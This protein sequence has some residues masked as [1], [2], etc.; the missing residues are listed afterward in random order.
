ML[1]RSR[2]N[3]GRDPSKVWRKDS[4]PEKELDGYQH[5]GLTRRVGIEDAP[6]GRVLDPDDLGGEPHVA[7]ADRI[8]GEPRSALGARLKR[9]V[10]QGGAHVRLEPLRE[11]EI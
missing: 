1:G 7:R 8:P 10:D 9:A 2:A 5:A 4:E 3:Y 6:I 11:G